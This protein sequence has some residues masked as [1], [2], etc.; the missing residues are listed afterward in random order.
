M[1]STNRLLELALKGLEVDRAKL[2]AEIA[3]IKSQ[4]K[5]TVAVRGQGYRNG[6]AGQ[7]KRRRRKMSAEARRK[8]SESMKRRHAGLSSA[9]QRSQGAA[10][11][12]PGGLTAAGRKKLSEM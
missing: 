8:I 2:D 1:P 4:L 12:R 11:S 10:K 6:E 9:R 5:I 3:E 7:T